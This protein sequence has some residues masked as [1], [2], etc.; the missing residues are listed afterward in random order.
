MDNIPAKLALQQNLALSQGLEQHRAGNLDAAEES[1]KQVLCDA[2]RHAP[3][4]HLLGLIARQRGQ[5][6]EAIALLR[7]SLES[8]RANKQVL[9]N[10]GGILLEAG[11]HHVAVQTLR[12]AVELKP[13]YGDAHHQLGRDDPERDSGNRDKA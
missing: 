10:L 7:Q 1:Y 5:L 8:V 13:D 2:P 11:D 9:S 4:L 12:R 3:A 6:S